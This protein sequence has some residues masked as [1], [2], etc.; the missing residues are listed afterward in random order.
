MKNWTDD[1]RIHYDAGTNQRYTTVRLSFVHR[2][3]VRTFK[4]AIPLEMRPKLKSE[5]YDTAVIVAKRTIDEQLLRCW[6]AGE[7]DRETNDRTVELMAFT[8]ILE[9]LYNEFHL[10]QAMAGN[11]VWATPELM[12]DV[13][14]KPESDEVMQ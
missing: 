1:G 7:F 14:P 9:H 10:V 8:A 2:L 6:A 5:H 13:G 4:L 12:Q 3:K 11:P